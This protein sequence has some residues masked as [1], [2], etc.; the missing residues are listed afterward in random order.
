MPG[1]GPETAAHCSRDSA[2]VRGS[3]LV[4]TQ[5]SITLSNAFPRKHSSVSSLCGVSTAMLWDER[6]SLTFSSSI[7]IPPQKSPSL[8]K[9]ASSDQTISSSADL[10]HSGLSHSSPVS[11]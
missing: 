3:E 5:N 6:L 2:D 7:S 11:Q 8:P 10:S 9:S 1:L 4:Q